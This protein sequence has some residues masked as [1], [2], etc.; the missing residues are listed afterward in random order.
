VIKA[1]RFTLQFHKKEKLYTDIY[2]F[3]FHAPKTFRYLPGQYLY[4][5]LPH[6]N[7]DDNGSTRYFTIAS[8]PS[9]EQVMITTRYTTS[10]FKKT[11][12]ALE[13]GAELVC[14]GPMGTFLLSA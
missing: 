4:V 5:I 6:D 2:S 8:S 12:F 3:Y 11:L 13:P 9:E 1:K 14:F 10:S 7:V